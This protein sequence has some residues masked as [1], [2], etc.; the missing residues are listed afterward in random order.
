MIGTKVN[1]NFF[2]NW[3]YDHR[4]D[5][6]FSVN[7]WRWRKKSRLDSET[8]KSSSRLAVI[9]MISVQIENM[10]YIHF[11]SSSFESHQL[12]SRWERKK[13][14][15]AS[16]IFWVSF[17]VRKGLIYS[18]LIFQLQYWIQLSRLPHSLFNFVALFEFKLKQHYH[19]LAF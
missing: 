5:S 17:W 16:H 15:D 19:T 4:N 18:H 10:A 11:S 9:F 13:K 1:L 6:H 7:C 12:V 8:K 2:F 14:F 3:I